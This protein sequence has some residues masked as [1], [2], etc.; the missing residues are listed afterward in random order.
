[1]Q[2]RIFPSSLFLLSLVAC[3]QSAVQSPQ[4]TPNASE[5]E[6]SQSEESVESNDL[7]TSSS[8]S[9]YGDPA[10]ALKEQ[11]SN[12]SPAAT[13]AEPAPITYQARTE[14]D[15]D[16]LE[17]SGELVKPQGALLFDRKAS[18]GIPMEDME[19]D[20]AP[21]AESMVIGSSSLG[22]KAQRY[23]GKVKSRKGRGGGTSGYGSGGGSF[24]AVGRVAPRPPAPPPNTEQYTNYG[25]NDMTASA[26][27]RFSTFSIDVDTASYTISRRKLQEGS[28]PPTASV[29]VEE[30][31]N[32][33]PYSY[34][35]PTTDAPF[36]VNMEAAP[37][38]FNDGH[39]LFRV[40]IKAQD[41]DLS[42]RKPVH[43]TFLVD[44]SGSMNRPDKLGLAKRS[45]RLLTDQLRPGDTVAL[46]TYAGNVRAVLDPTD[47]RHKSQIHTAIEDLSAGGST[48]MNS[49][50][51]LAYRMAQ[52]SAKPGHENRVVVLSDGDA[53]VGPASH[54]AILESIKGYAKKGITLSTIGLGMGNYKDTMME[55]LANKGDGNYYYIDSFSEAKK[56]FGT[57]LAGTLQVIAK[58][59]K[60]QVEFNPETVAT[61]RLIGYENRD[62]ADKDFRNDKVDAGEIGTGH[63][64]TALYDLVL[65]DGA[66]EELA[67]VR[68][69]NKKP[70]PDSPAV[71]WMTSFDSDELASRF[72]K[73]SPDF[74]VAIAAATFAEILRG[75]PYAAEVSWQELAALAS[76][77]QRPGVSEDDELLSL[78][79]K[80][81]SLS[82][83]RG[84]TAER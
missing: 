7:L 6:L 61:Y 35:A 42:N 78:I 19:Y 83:A 62:I 8:Q 82:G 17:V 39:H 66:D 32:Y 72:S 70:G 22:A 26:T 33:F 55:Q 64:V 25:V 16:G 3:T 75:S 10:D 38:P 77:A 65:A 14:I 53:N 4:P 52:S 34:D 11:A 44:V 30:F 49:G 69:R 84:P 18:P 68:I 63:T 59:V 56:V 57:N 20:M 67:T 36:A 27:D 41:L 9:S 76:E 73:A 2:T 24:G 60:I 74:R 45:L 12:I 29:R 13:S 50:I 37:H 79:Q 58:D 1:M 46:A 48:A 43:L 15:F 80:A 54:Q 47:I 23:E 71:E 40:G 21:Q 5:P 28:L 51:Q 81:A 31:V